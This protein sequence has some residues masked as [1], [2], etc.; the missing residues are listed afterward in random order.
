MEDRGLYRT[1]RH[2]VNGSSAAAFP[3][4]RREVEKARAFLERFRGFPYVAPLA[5]EAGSFFIE[6]IMMRRLFFAGWLLCP[7]VGQAV[8]F[9]RDIAPILK[10]QCY[11]CHSDAT[12][13]KKNGYVFDNLETLAGDIRAGGMIDPGRP[14]ESEFLRLLTAPPGDDR[15]M[16]PKG[17]GLSEKEIKL[18]TEWIKEGAKLEKQ[19]AGKPSGLTPKKDPEKPA[20]ETPPPAVAEQWTSADGKVITA[21][22]VAVEGAV[23]V[24]KMNGKPYRVPLAKLS[25]ASRKQATER[26]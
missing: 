5:T 14:E 25:E 2:C 10:K 26:K 17:D 13:K 7:A 16:P 4:A 8:D 1:C 11:E 21:S 12:G 15:R 19:T 24:L 9:K 23:V 20:A 3:K 18:V 22:F 6:S